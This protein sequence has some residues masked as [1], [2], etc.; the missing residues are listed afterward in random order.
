MSRRPRIH[1]PGLPIH[2]VQRGH[3]RDACFFAYEDFLAC[4]E[5]LGE[6]LGKIGGRP[7]FSGARRMSVAGVKVRGLPPF[8]WRLRKQDVK[9]WSVPHFPHF[10]TPFSQSQTQEMNHE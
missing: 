10:S 1:L 5:W 9:P 8:L 6:A 3:N 7:R 4:Q 2:L